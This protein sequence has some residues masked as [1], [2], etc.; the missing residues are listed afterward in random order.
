MRP[1]KGEHIAYHICKFE[2]HI[3]ARPNGERE[4]ARGLR[5]IP[6][7]ELKK[8]IRER[9]PD[10]KSM[11]SELMLTVQLVATTTAPAQANPCSNKRALPGLS[12][13]PRVGQVL[14]IATI[15]SMT[16]TRIGVL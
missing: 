11:Y 2:E 7:T 16:E 13:A 3:L 5:P 12:E 8:D 15:S 10:G 14:Q 1:P 4:W 9:I 6:E